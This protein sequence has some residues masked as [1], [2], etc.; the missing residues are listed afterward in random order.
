MTAVF[1]DDLAAQNR[2]E[3]VFWAGIG[4]GVMLSLLVSVMSKVTD[5][6]LE[7]LWRKGQVRP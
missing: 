5:A 1:Q 7:D 4:L 2:R 6:V 3:D